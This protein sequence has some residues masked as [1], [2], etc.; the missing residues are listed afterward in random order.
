MSGP[1]RRLI[2]CGISTPCS[3]LNELDRVTSLQYF[4]SDGLWHPAAPYFL[5]T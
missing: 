3:Y 1:I 4:P 2:V 5:R